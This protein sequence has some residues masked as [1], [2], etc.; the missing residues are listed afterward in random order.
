MKL[1]RECLKE[2][3]REVVCDAC[4]RG[5]M[6]RLPKTGTINHDAKKSLDE[7][8]V[9]VMG[10]MRAETHDGYKYVLV[11]VDVYSRYLHVS[12]MK[13]KGEATSMLMDTITR[14]QAR[15]EL[16]VKKLYSDGGKE[17]VNNELGE[18]LRK[19]GTMH[20]T[21][22]PHTPEHNGL[23]ERANRTIM[24]MVRSMMIHCDSV[25]QFW[26]EA[27]LTATRVLQRT[28]TRANKKRTP[29]ELY[30][31]QDKMFYYLHAF[32]C[33]AYYYIH[34]PH[35]DGKLD[36]VA[37]SAIFLGYEWTNDAYYRLYDVTTNKI[38][39][40]TDVKF[41]DDNFTNMKR[42]KEKMVSEKTH[43]NRRSD[44]DALPDFLTVEMIEQLFTTDR[45]NHGDGNANSRPSVSSGSPPS[46][47]SASPAGTNTNTQLEEEENENDSN[48][49]SS[50]DVSLRGSDKRDKKE[51]EEDKEET[52]VK[53]R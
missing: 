36:A 8:A 18:Y 16:K 27:V 13:T 30:D 42:L 11:I 45:S 10:P 24:E 26:G 46:L 49:T 17:F 33:D 34:K 19:N 31:G 6:T 12:L 52:D 37:T 50:R 23:V 2:M 40:S 20:I 25:V 21:T 48:D 28:L 39:L 7:W 51:R 35:R 44:D 47:S 4:V 41:F 38:V 32:G 5:K 43:T 29:S 3:K 14:E 53:H 22:T 9:D 1:V 15:F